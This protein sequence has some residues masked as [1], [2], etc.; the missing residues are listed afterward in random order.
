MQI[1]IDRIERQ[2]CR[3]Q[4]K[5][6]KRRLGNG[7]KTLAYFSNSSE[8]SDY[9]TR[10]CEN[11]INFRDRDG[12]LGSS[13]CPILDLHYEYNYDQCKKTK[14]G[15]AIKNILEQLIPTKADGLFA[16]ECSMFIDR[17]ATPDKDAEYLETL[18]FGDTVV[19]GQD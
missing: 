19:F 6:I 1:D 14:L 2:F 4:R 3:L 7:E 12:L 11:C 18:R 9:E 15:K 10:Y 8:G 16:D 13:S 5:G 17:N